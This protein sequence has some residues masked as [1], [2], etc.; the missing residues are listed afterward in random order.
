M[1]QG[2]YIIQWITR[3]K[4]EGC[5]LEPSVFYINP[6]YSKQVSAPSLLIFS[7]LLIFWT[8]FYSPRSFTNIIG[9][10]N[11]GFCCVYTFLLDLTVTLFT[12]VFNSCWQPCFFLDH[13]CPTPG[14]D[15][16]GHKSGLFASHRRSVSNA[17]SEYGLI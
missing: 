7:C 6:K 17:L 10:K 1:L 15:G 8:N 3:D 13:R 4:V 2:D 16:S 5:F 9:L 11:S 14:C 12:P